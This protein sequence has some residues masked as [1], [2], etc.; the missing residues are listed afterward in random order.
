MEEDKK[1]NIKGYMLAILGGVSWGI[2][3]VC[4]QYLFTQYDLSADWLTAIRTD[5]FCIC[6]RH[7]ISFRVNKGIEV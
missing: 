1:N 7:G 3:G 6:C 5:R 2:S 4:S